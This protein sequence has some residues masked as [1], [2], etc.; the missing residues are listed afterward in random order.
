MIHLDENVPGP[1]GT[2]ARLV[3]ASGIG[4]VASLPGV[5]PFAVR[6]CTIPDLRW[7]APGE[8]CPIDVH[9]RRQ[10]AIDAIGAPGVLKVTMVAVRCTALAIFN[11][12]DLEPFAAT[13][14]QFRSRTS[15]V[16]QEVMR[17][18]RRRWGIDGIVT[19]ALDDE[20]AKHIALTVEALST[21]NTL[22]RSEGFR[23]S[24]SRIGV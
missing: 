16:S 20:A 11:D 2:N 15:V 21:I 22:D 1:A 23:S 19:S 14:E 3:V 9:D 17:W 8:T 7:A 5:D 12:D 6:R 24:R 4:Y 10:V 18:I 13:L